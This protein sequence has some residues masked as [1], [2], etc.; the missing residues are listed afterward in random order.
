[1]SRFHHYIYSEEEIA[2]WQMLRA[3]FAGKFEG[4]I[5]HDIFKDDFPELAAALLRQGNPQAILSIEEKIVRYADLRIFQEKV[6][7]K[8]QR[9]AYLRERYP[10]PDDVWRGYEEKA[11]RLEK[12][13]FS[14]LPFQPEELAAL[15]ENEAIK[16]QRENG[17]SP[18]SVRSM[19][20]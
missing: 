7:P 14:L 15:L 11:G 2:M 20:P 6:V 5:A 8:E 18:L 3:K 10:R 9:F 17:S 4:E 19:T 16:N 12:E 13:M 1:S